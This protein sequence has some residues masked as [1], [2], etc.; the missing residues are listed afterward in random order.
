MAKKDEIITDLWKLTTSI[1]KK[2]EE[3]VSHNPH[4]HG[5]QKCVNSVSQ[6]W[7]DNCMDLTYSFRETLGSNIPDNKESK[8]KSTTI[9]WKST[10]DALP[11]SESHVLAIVDRTDKNGKKL[12]FVTHLVR[13]DGEVFDGSSDYGVD[14]CMENSIF[15]YD[16]GD[17]KIPAG[18]YRFV[19]GE[20]GCHLSEISPSD[21][22]LYWCYISDTTDGLVK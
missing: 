5:L 20:A 22:V 1:A 9:G 3:V 11:T 8:D 16:R 6:F 7:Q 4:L 19:D 17:Y 15:D 14:Y 18:W 10:D 2:C 21:K 12:R 13:E